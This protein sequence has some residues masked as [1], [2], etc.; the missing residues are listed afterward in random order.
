MIKGSGCGTILSARVCVEEVGPKLHEYAR[1]CTSGRS[2][3]GPAAEVRARTVRGFLLEGTARDACQCAV[4]LA[5][6]DQIFL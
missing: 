4:R 1:I 2:G 3:L 6:V 5:T